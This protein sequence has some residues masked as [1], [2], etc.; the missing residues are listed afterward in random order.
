MIL[1]CEIDVKVPIIFGRPFLSTEKSLIDAE[2]GEL[3]FQM[4]GEEVTFNVWKLMKQPSDLHMISVIDVIDEAVAS[5]NEVSCVRESLVV[6]LLN[7]DVEE[8][9]D[10]DKVVASLSG[11]GSYSKTFETWYHFEEEGKSSRKAIY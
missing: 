5:M 10:Y 1:N 6:V 2:S 8:I 7:Y 4:N 3:K 11:L 9:E